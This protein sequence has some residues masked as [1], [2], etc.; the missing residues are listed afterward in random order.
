[1]R[2]F[3]YLLKYEIRLLFLS[4]ATYIAAVI[5]L[6]LMAFIYLF[7]I[8]GYNQTPQETLSST[9]LFRS[10]WIPVFFVVPLLTMKSISEEKRLGT[11]EA[12]LT[13]S[14]TPI[15]IVFSK[16]L[17][18]YL[19]YILLWLTT[20]SYPLIVTYFISSASASQSLADSASLI[21]GLSFIAISGTLYVS[22]G[23]FA[24][25][26]TRSQLVAGTLCF[27]LLFLV[28]VGGRILLQTEDWIQTT[29]FSLDYF[30]TFQQLEDFSRGIIDTRPFFFYIGNSLLILGL[31]S[32]FLKTKT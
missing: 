25:S 12:L 8:Q 27:S 3:I 15:A 17:C 10:F 32:L 29:S 2:Q 5:F 16:F 24:S 13:T 26:L 23:I 30:Q 6:S 1:M 4:P 14:A 21:G 20:L 31:T 7:I 9:E 19:F 22:L 28:I 18:A 11:L